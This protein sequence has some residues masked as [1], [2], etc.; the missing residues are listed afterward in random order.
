[1]SFFRKATFVATGG[2]SGMVIKAN[3]KKERTAKAMEDQV[4]LQKQQIELQRPARTGDAIPAMMGS[5][6]PV[7]QVAPWSLADELA[8]LAALREQGILTN[9]EFDEQKHRLLES[10]RP[11]EP[12]PARETEKRTGGFLAGLRAQAQAGAAA[13]QAAVKAK[14]DRKAPTEAAKLKGTAERGAHLSDDE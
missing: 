11:P 13:G 14:Q 8:K 2:A 10:Q 6:P 1:M 12:A 9:E 4:R 5:S 7:P 3:S